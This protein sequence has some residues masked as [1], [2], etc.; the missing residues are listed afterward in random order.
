[1]CLHVWMWVCSLEGW[2]LLR[3]QPS[4]GPEAGVTGGCELPQRIYKLVFPYISN[5]VPLCHL[6]V[7]HFHVYNEH[8]WAKALNYNYSTFS[9]THKRYKMMLLGRTIPTLCI[10]KWTTH[11]GVWWC[12]K[13][14]L[15]S[16]LTHLSGWEEKKTH[17]NNINLLI[18]MLMF[19]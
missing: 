12:P 3:P 16:L 8:K 4:D 9:F 14:E 6:W 17:C 2:C 13:H 11:T 1:M 7:L 5:S 18:L 19:Q 15:T 10:Q